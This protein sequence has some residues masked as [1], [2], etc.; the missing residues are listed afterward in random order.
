M[1]IGTETK[2]IDAKGR[3]VIPSKFRRNAGFDGEEGFYVTPGPGPY[4]MMFTS[5]EWN[6]FTSRV[7]RANAGSGDVFDPQRHLFP[8]AE[9]LPLDKQGR[10]VLPPSHLAETE[11]GL[12]VAILGMGNHIELWNEERWQVYRKESL[13]RRDPAL[14][15]SYLS[16]G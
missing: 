14:W 2:S 12:D 8:E 7:S 5:R 16:P 6:R 4:L 9:F 11:L 15:R 3:L 13:S 1:F 10:I